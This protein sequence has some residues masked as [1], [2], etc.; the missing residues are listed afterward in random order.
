MPPQGRFAESQAPASHGANPP[1]EDGEGVSALGPPPP[2]LPP[3]RPA[4]PLPPAATGTEGP[5]VT[6]Q[7]GNGVISLGRRLARD[8][9]LTVMQIHGRGRSGSAFWLLSQA[10]DPTPGP[11]PGL[12][13]DPSGPPP[14][15][16]PKSQ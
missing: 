5:I 3:A 11:S 15:T 4:H 10:E 1:P 2:K 14:R 8:K 16:E 9:G 7:A 6:S 13:L 12:T